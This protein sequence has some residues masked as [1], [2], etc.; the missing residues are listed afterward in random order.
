[1]GGSAKFLGETSVKM[2]I[3]QGLK[4]VLKLQLLWSH[5]SQRNIF[6]VMGV[7]INF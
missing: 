4:K 7:F 6:S 5:R 1:M 3:F 2:V